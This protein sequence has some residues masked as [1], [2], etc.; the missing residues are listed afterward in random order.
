MNKYNKV[1]PFNFKGVH[2]YIQKPFEIILKLYLWKFQY[3][4]YTTNNY[5]NNDALDFFN[6]S[7]EKKVE[8][9]FL[10]I[11]HVLSNISCDI[12]RE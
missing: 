9:R 7:N 4:K 8:S 5:L 2:I 10:N 3:Y 12:Y 1:T 6:V 11:L